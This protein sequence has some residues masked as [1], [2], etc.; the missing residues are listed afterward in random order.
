MDCKNDIWSAVHFIFYLQPPQYVTV[1]RPPSKSD[2][3]LALSV[4]PSV[5]G[6]NFAQ[7]VGLLLK[8]FVKFCIWIS[9]SC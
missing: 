5:L 9:L 2:R 1:I 4:T 6:V 8:G 7:I 3:R